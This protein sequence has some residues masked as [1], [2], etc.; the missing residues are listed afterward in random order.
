MELPIKLSQQIAYNARANTEKHM[1]I[2]PLLTTIT[3]SQP[4]QT[5]NEQIEIAVSFL[6]GPIGIFNVTNKKIQF[7][8]KVSFIDFDFSVISIPPGAYEI[9]GLNRNQTKYF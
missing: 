8:F 5:N 4:L 1:S 9:E 7:Y 3:N 6:T 2:V